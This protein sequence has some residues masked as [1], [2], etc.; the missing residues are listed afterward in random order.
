M[1][2]GI[3]KIRP[4]GHHH[5]YKYAHA[6]DYKDVKEIIPNYRQDIEPDGTWEFPFENLKNTGYLQ[7][8]LFYKWLELKNWDDKA[9]NCTL[10]S[11]PFSNSVN[12]TKF[13][14]TWKGAGAHAVPGIHLNTSIKREFN[15]KYLNA[16]NIDSGLSS[17]SAN[18][19]SIL[20]V[21]A[22]K[23][24]NAA[25]FLSCEYDTYSSNFTIEFDTKNITN[26]NSF[27]KTYEYRTLTDELK[28]PIDEDGEHT[29]VSGK[30]QVGFSYSLFPNLSTGNGMFSGCGLT[31][32]YTIAFLNSIPDWSNDTAEHNLTIGICADY[33]YDSDLNLLLKSIDKNYITPIEKIGQSLPE[34]VTVDKGWNLTVEWNHATSDE[35]LHEHIKEKLEFDTIVLPDG[36]TRCEY[37]EDTGTQWINTNYIPTVNTGLYVIAKSILSGNYIA[38]GC[39]EN[40]SSNSNTKNPSFNVPRWM[41]AHTSSGYNY[42]NWNA[43]TNYGSGTIYE[44]WNNYKNDKK[45]RIFTQ[46]YEN[47]ADLNESINFGTSRDAAIHIFGSTVNGISHSLPWNG[48][49]YRAQITEG[50]NIIKDF[51]PCLDADG[52]PCM[53]DIIEPK[54]YYNESTTSTFLYKIAEL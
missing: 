4:C 31:K 6:K 25:Y 36:Y 40:I 48:R 54:A 19:D 13:N 44:G 23:A 26:A 14:F 53:Y 17:F 34:E 16:T 8:S 2:G 24:T 42:G 22:P 27:L 43:W 38:M 28:Y 12:L 41:K 47:S 30:E 51:I 50:D 15:L 18:K 10:N 1:I 29:F 45:A 46:G 20:R 37:L 9:P 7:N 32:E 33:G 11:H 39:G 5:Y 52:V 21:Y 35:P 49:I 3:G